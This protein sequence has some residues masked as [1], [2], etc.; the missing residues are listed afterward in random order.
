LEWIA[1]FLAYSNTAINPFIYIGI[2]EN[3]KF[4]KIKIN[5]FIKIKFH[6]K[7]E[8]F[9]K[10]VRLFGNR[11]KSEIVNGSSFRSSNVY[12]L[13]NISS[14]RHNSLKKND[15]KSS[16]HSKVEGR[17]FSSEYDGISEFD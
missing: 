13:K 3:F 6:N 16:M 9:F 12:R 1:Y 4:S 15:F 2:S 14:P 11:L 10:G 5:T 17:S 8:N 7:L